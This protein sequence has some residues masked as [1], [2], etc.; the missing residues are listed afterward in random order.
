MDSRNRVLPYTVQVCKNFSG[1]NEEP[2]FWLEDPAYGEAYSPICVKTTVKEKSLCIKKHLGVSRAFLFLSLFQSV[3][4][5]HSK[6]NSSRKA[7]ILH[8]VS[9][10][11]VFPF[12]RWLWIYA[13]DKV[14]P[15]HSV[16]SLFAVT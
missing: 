10:L 3:P 9:A 6:N 14:L 2:L 13:C 1:E 7:W 5:K 15:S 16:I 12:C 4:T 11:R 8:H